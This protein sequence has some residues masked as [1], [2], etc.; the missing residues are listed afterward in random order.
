MSTKAKI[1]V[2]IVMGAL[3]FGL[4]VIEIIYS[5]GERERQKPPEEK[6]IVSI[7]VQPT[8]QPVQPPVQ[9]IQ[10]PAQ[11]RPPEQV[12]ISYETPKESREPL[13]PQAESVEPTQPTPTEEGQYYVIKRGDTFESLAEKHYGS[14]NKWS[15]IQD[16]NPGV[17][18][19]RLKIGQKILI[20]TKTT[21][22]E[23][24]PV[25]TVESEKTYIVKSGD[26]LEGISMRFY[27][28]RRFAQKI[29]DANKEKIENP[30]SL[31]VGTKIVIPEVRK[32]EPAPRREEIPQEEGKKSYVVKPGD[33]LWKIANTIYKDS[34]YISKIQKLNKD[35]IPTTDSSLR[36]GM[37]LRLPD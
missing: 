31:K 1:A 21:E 28:S 14:K 34:S 29:F 9:P 37:V 32:E 33:S 26:T 22:P 8:P 17:N 30:N 18:P 2:L 23:T 10:P 5:G 4:V 7:P 25:E 13:K 16:A 11:P 36:P 35:K 20:P 15:I 6:K 3:I 12:P 27:K 19:K 24:T